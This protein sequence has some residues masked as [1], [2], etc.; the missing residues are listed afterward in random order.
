MRHVQ[1]W[2]WPPPS[3]RSGRRPWYRRAPWQ[4]DHAIKLSAGHGGHSRQQGDAAVPGCLASVV[5]R[6]RAELP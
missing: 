2:I 6:R 3:G 5:R 4:L 1:S